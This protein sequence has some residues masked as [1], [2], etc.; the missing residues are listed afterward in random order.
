MVA[1]GDDLS[2]VEIQNPGDAALDLSGY[3]L[4]ST[5]DY[6]RLVD[7]TLEDGVAGWIAGF[8]DGFV[9][10]PGRA[11]VL[12][13]GTPEAFAEAHGYVPEAVV[14]E[15]VGSTLGLALTSG[16]LT[17]PVPE[18]GLVALFR[19]DGESDL[20]MDA[21]LVFWGEDG[22]RVD[23][24]GVEVD[25][26]D[27]D[28]EATPYPAE[29]ASLDQVP[30]PS[31]AVGEARVCGGD[32]GEVAAGGSGIDGVDETSE[33]LDGSLLSA[34][35]SPEAAVTIVGVLSEGSDGSVTFTVGDQTVIGAVTAGAFAVE[36][37]IEAELAVRLTV[38]DGGFT[39]TYTTGVESV[40]DATVDLQE[41]FSVSGT[42]TAGDTA[43]ALEGAVVTLGA[44]AQTTDETGGYAFEVLAG[45]YD[46][47]VEA[48][49]YEPRAETLEVIGSQTKDVELAPS[50]RYSLT[51]EVTLG[52]SGT[53][54][55]ASVSLRGGE[56]TGAAVTE[57]GADGVAVFEGLRA[58]N[59]GVEVSLSGY[60][61]VA[62][63]TI[64]VGADAEFIVVLQPVTREPSVDRT[65]KL[66]C[67][68]ASGP[69]PRSGLWVV[70]GALLLWSLR[71]RESSR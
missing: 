21:D 39:G 61:T 26:P 69:S 56:L 1:P 20:V 57:V 47:S 68:A 58:G 34:V 71:V 8:P 54:Q 45:T 70:V 59:Y 41:V 16:D 67:S 28:M 4:A 44:E 27:E 6:Y 24:N 23:R 22:P 40:R 5:P 12:I 17:A 49:G 65:E 2:F 66:D 29:T 60:G 11:V 9:L 63:E 50:L 36:L 30:A 51:V 25:G 10:P 3:Y 35:P 43:G 62:I 37:P 33:E 52:D 42:V 14:G 15:G 53:A 13:D 46:F 64:P 32:G 19:W 38:E 18:S 31:P 55:G 48:A 7:G